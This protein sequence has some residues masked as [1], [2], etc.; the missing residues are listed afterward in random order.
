MEVSLALNRLAKLRLPKIKRR[1]K[2][3]ATHLTTLTLGREGTGWLG[4]SVVKKSPSERGAG[5]KDCKVG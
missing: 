1:T 3:S 2:R 5:R 4:N